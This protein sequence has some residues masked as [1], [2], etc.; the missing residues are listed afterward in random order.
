[1]LLSSESN[2]RHEISL[3][4][5]KFVAQLEEFLSLILASKQTNVNIGHSFCEIF[6]FIGH[7]LLHG[8]DRLLTKTSKVN[9]LKRQ[10]L[11]QR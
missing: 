8:T 1:M 10:A 2:E 3:I 6:R 5:V 7:A 9:L 4:V 11:V